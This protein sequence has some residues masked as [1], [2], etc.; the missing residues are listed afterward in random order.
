MG[1]ICEVRLWDG[2]SSHDYIPNFIKTDS[3]IQK[4]RGVGAT[5]HGD[6]ISL[7]SLLFKNKRSGLKI[8]QTQ[9]AVHIKYASDNEQ[10]P[11]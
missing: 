10:C 7:V 4:L 8:I 1:G 9:H 2:L 5:Q 6:C 3:A 11:T